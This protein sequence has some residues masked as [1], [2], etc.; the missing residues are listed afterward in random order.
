MARKRIGMNALRMVIELHHKTSLSFRRI[1]EASGV[2]RPVV[3]QYIQNFSRTGLSFEEFSVLPDSQLLERL[4]ESKP[5]GD[6][7][8]PV[9]LEF[10]PYAVAELSRV[11]VTRELLWRE[12]KDKHP[13][14]YQYTQFC[15]YFNL[16]R[17]ADPEV[18]MHIEHKAGDRMYVDFT[19]KK[20]SY[21][22]SRSGEIKQAEI[23]VALLGASQYT[24]IEAVRSQR[25]EDWIAANRNALEYF[26]G[27]PASIMPDCLKSGVT[28]ADKYEPV[29]N[30]EYADFARYYGT[31]ITPARPH[32]PRDKALVEGAVK[33]AYTRIL[34]PLRNRDFASLDELN[35][36]IWE[37]L[38][39]YNSKEFQKLPHSRAQLFESIEKPALRS[40]PARRYEL[41]SFKTVTVGFNYH[42]ELRE[43]RHNYS[44][45]F[46]FAKKSVTV[47]YNTRTVEIYQ[48]NVRIAFHKR[49]FV[50]GYTTLR[51]HMPAHHQFYLEWSPERL[52]R[53]AGDVSVHTK[54]LVAVILE[55]AQYPEQAYKQCV[56]II[57]FSKKHS[58]ER[59]DW[60]CQR[61]ISYSSFSYRAVKK[62][63][64]SEKVDD[65]PKA[66]R[67]IPFHDNLRGQT[68]YQ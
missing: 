46:R 7:R 3:A 14:G 11:G 9:L 61:A 63:L 38:E 51:E 34:A 56:G 36:A 65:K 58:V 44:V 22:E 49:L 50:P 12:Y 15:H 59:L 23:F 19:G 48:D 32:S 35:T 25:K 10:F 1:S 30:P 24:Y 55:R 62:L 5:T 68:A 27:V 67:V 39:A 40:L 64:E 29:I 45:P 37:L 20:Q 18:T 57:S 60:A 28:V 2:S 4:G 21:R 17:T 31:V 53:W 33:I 13:Q 43:D 42:I 8:H 41:T 47:A 26:G 6:P 52:I 54:A 16:W 66:V